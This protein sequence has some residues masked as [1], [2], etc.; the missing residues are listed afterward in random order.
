MANSASLA[1][2]RKEFAAR[3]WYK[4][5]TGWAL[6]G[7][8]INLLLALGGIFVFIIS[9]NLL[10]RAGA[11]LVSTAGS[12]GVGTN[13]HTSSHYATSTK[14]WINEL[15]TYFGFPF[16]L[17]LSATCWW[18]KHIALHHTAPKVPGVDDDLDLWPWFAMTEEEVKRSGNFLQLYYRQLQWLVFPIV[19]MVNC[20]HMQVNGW[21]YLIRMLRDSRKR[22]IF[23]WIDLGSL[24]L[25]FVTTLVIPLCYFQSAHVFTFYLLRFGLMGYA[26]F[27][28]LAPGH[29]PVEA[30]CVN[31]DQ[32]T[33]DYLLL[34]TAA[35]V[36]FRTGFIGRLI[37]SGLENQIEHHL[38]PNVTHVYYPKMRTAVETFCKEHGLPY[39]SFRWKNAIWKSFMAL[40]KPQRIESELEA[41]RLRN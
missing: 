32:R 22:K 9:S 4:K 37:C 31:K 39:R 33:S 25:H 24:L 14:R 35:T 17:G 23:H 40:R 16:F 38:F 20:F 7:L 6:L 3:G 10:I 18:H 1:L 34:Q 36:N 41:L 21:L 28:V 11:I 8:L 12:L 27:A 30:A 5:A 13:S 19:L 15:L 26:M 2:L 29:F